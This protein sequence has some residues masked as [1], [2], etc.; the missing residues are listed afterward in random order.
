MDLTLATSAISA[1]VVEWHRAR[2]TLSDHDLI[3]FDVDVRPS[4]RSTTMSNW[5]FA[6]DNLVDWGAFGSALDSNVTRSILQLAQCATSANSLDLLASDIQDLFM[7]AASET[8]RAKRGPRL[9]R[10][11]QPVWWDAECIASMRLYKAACRTAESD[12]TS[13]GLRAVRKREYQKL[14]RNKR[15]SSWRS[16]IEEA[17]NSSAWGNLY[18]V[19]KNELNTL[20][21]D[22][23]F[24]QCGSAQQ[25]NTKLGEVLNHFFPDSVGP[26]NATLVPRSSDSSSTVLKVTL[27]HINRLLESYVNVRKAPGPDG[28]SNAMLKATTVSQRLMIAS[29]FQRCIDLEHFPLTWKDARVIFVP[30]PGKEDYSDPCS[31]RPI[32]LLSCLGK[33]FEKLLSEW[34]DQHLEDS[35]LVSCNQYGFRKNRS[36]I[37]ALDAL[38]RCAKDRRA[39]GHKVAMI[40]FD[41]KGAFD[42]V[43]WTSIMREL[44]RLHVPTK[45]VNLIASYL[46]NRVVSCSF[47]GATASKS[48]SK[49]SPQGSV[50]SPLLW[51]IVMNSFLAKFSRPNSLAVAYADDITIVCWDKDPRKLHS[52]C[53]ASVLCVQSWCQA[54]ELELSLSKTKFISIGTKLENVSL[55]ER[56][57]FIKVLGILI[58]DRLSFTQHICAQI[59]KC[60]KARFSLQ[61]YC[62]RN[63]GLN[64]RKRV[65]LY[66]AWL[67]PILSY[68]AE[69]WFPYINKTSIKKLRSC[70]HLMLKFCVKGYRTISYASSLTLSKVKGVERFLRDKHE[71][72]LVCAR[73]CESLPEHLR[74]VAK[75]GYARL[76]KANLL[77]RR[78]RPARSAVDAEVS[79]TLD[80]QRTPAYT[81]AGFQI[82]SGSYGPYRARFAASRRTSDKLALARALRLSLEYL[83]SE[84]DLAGCAI[85]VNLKSP[86]HLVTR[87]KFSTDQIESMRIMRDNDLRVHAIR[88]EPGSELSGYVA[89]CQRARITLRG[90][91]RRGISRALAPNPE[92]VER[93]PTLGEFFTV[94]VPDWLH[95]TYYTTVFFTG[96]GPFKSYLNR[97]GL[98]GTDLCSCVGQA[99]QTVRHILL[100]C[101]HFKGLVEQSFHPRPHTLS[102][103][104]KDTT[105]YGKFMDLCKEVYTV[106]I[107]NTTLTH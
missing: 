46:R 66:T 18:K 68:G 104:V 69:I 42:N 102:D 23:L 99:P 55:I 17:E 105:S 53:E 98:S 5:R 52:N 54:N 49:G 25:L 29:V 43:S 92:A 67:R 64:S 48:T 86:Q 8:L 14:L 76:F 12:P 57:P 94:A 51:N 77:L 97:F 82:E 90:M 70:E 2:H 16:F 15:L 35:D 100:D 91:T 74:D 50:L 59:S 63:F 103:F 72:H 22:S 88:S 80:V 61:K 79:V 95:T 101:D 47:G 20:K 58:D 75:E 83:V 36:A 39:S 44:D 4:R 62:G 32:S 28:I 19:I 41:I 27:D 73:P 9:V 6:E 106:L 7:M 13:V 30:K 45:L 78:V 37:D 3:W 85:A 60:Q 24:S 87:R 65:Q 96:H 21:I 71:S 89:S 107:Q 11:V 34:L 93:N 26:R 33:M 1:R 81:C 38:V 10:K 56:S 84:H 40:T 31:Y